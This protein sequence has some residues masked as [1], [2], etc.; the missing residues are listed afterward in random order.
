[1]IFHGR[2]ADAKPLVDVPVAELVDPVHQKHAP[3]LKRHRIDCLFVKAEQVVGVQSPFLLRSA[4]RVAVL[5]ER[6]DEDVMASLVPSAIDEQVLRDAAEKSARI[7]ELATLP[8]ACG[9]REDFLHE[10]GRLLGTGL[11]A[12]KSEERT[13]MFTI[14]LVELACVC[15]CRR[16]IAVR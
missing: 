3:R 14:G 6:E 10:I 1:M 11:T 4:R 5:L 12:K 8:A 16:S 13:A 9:T 7:D 2:D 15:R